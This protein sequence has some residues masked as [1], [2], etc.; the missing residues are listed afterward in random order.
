[1]RVTNRK[2]KRLII[3]IA[4]GL[5]MIVLFLG[6]WLTILLVPTT[7][8]KAIR[9]RIFEDLHPIIAI[10]SKP[11]K[12][13]QSDKYAY[14]GKKSWIYYENSVTYVSSL[15]GAKISTFGV[16]K[17]HKGSFFYKAR[18]VEPIA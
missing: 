9:L 5:V 4:S 3:S 15:E 13:N 10:N 14:S 16:S 7:P 1:M 8:E 17:T 11:K 2:A 12:I 6:I 18:V